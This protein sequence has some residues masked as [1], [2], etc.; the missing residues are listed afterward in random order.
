MFIPF[1]EPV[2]AKSKLNSV[3]DPNESDQSGLHWAAITISFKTKSVVYK[4]S[5]LNRLHAEKAVE[6]IKGCLM[7]LNSK[8]KADKGFFKAQEWTFVINGNT[9]Q[10]ANGY[11]CGVFVFL[12]LLEAALGAN[13]PWQSEDIAILR[14]RIAIQIL[15]SNS[16]PKSFALDSTSPHQEMPWP[17]AASTK[18]PH[19]ATKPP[20]GNTPTHQLP[21]LHW[22]SHRSRQSFRLV[23]HK[24]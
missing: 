5:L 3:L 17:I 1:N 13:L 23:Y 18:N 21:A 10:Q 20:S 15:H 12:Y 11:D 16:D 22:S 14:P 2:V 8:R 19:Q 7:A 9:P 4:S 24:G 6:L